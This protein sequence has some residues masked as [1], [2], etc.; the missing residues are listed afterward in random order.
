MKDFDKGLMN[1]YVE[2]MEESDM[3]V[4]KLRFKGY[5]SFT[6][7]YA[8]INEFANIT[9]FI[10]RNNSGKSS[11]IDIIENLISP[12]KLAK[13]QREQKDLKIE[14]AHFL[15]DDEVEKVFRKD[16]SGG[17]IQ[18][19]HYMFVQKYAGKEMYFNLET[20][21]KH[22]SGE[23]VSFEYKYSRVPNDKEFDEKY[24][25]YWDRFTNFENNDFSKYMF[26]RLEAERN[27]VAEGEST[28][29]DVDS[30]GTGA[31]NLIRKFLNYSE[32]DENIIE[33]NLINALNL[34]IFPDSKFTGIRVQQIQGEHGLLWE[35]FLQ[36]GRNRYAISQM[37]SGLKTVI[38]VLINLLLIP[39]TQE[40]KGK[41]IIYAF[42]ELENNLHPALQRRLFD[43]LY[44]Y[45][46][47]YDLMIYLTTHS[48]VAINAYCDRE[49]TQ[50]Y[51]V[52]KENGSSSLHK[53]DDY[54]AKSSLLNDLDVRASDLLQ[55]NGIVWVEGPSDRVYIKRWLEVFG[56]GELIEGRDYQIL[57]YGGRLL[58][59][60]SADDKQKE[61]LN[62]L[63][64]N[65][66]A[67]IVM[68]SDKRGRRSHIN[69][70]KKRVKEEFESFH[71]LCWITQGKEIENYI[72]YSA[73]EQAYDRKLDRQCGQYDL[74]PDYIKSIAP[75]FSGEKV[76]FA[77]KVCKYISAENSSEILDLKKQIDK[78][79][80]TIR[81]WNPKV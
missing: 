7:K 47:K 50:I 48:H 73:I 28:D 54:I 55:S 37:G 19:N 60:Y 75:H 79:I 13:R 39:Q 2:E 6:E 10:G 66:N 31:T 69:D 72:P 49:N 36:E 12:A 16:T 51:H 41:R 21:S 56:G 58:A 80:N 63:I 40:Y 74:F 78:L 17:M 8:A 57:Y 70:T 11:C 32:Y 53:I 61:L 29:E 9:V 34:I 5:K 71:A 1:Q 30:R 59:H 46:V 22:Y 33:K 44:E 25:A 24:H 45:S 27:I 76:I 81:R 67:A 18:G 20:K 38:L 64:T 15:T 43:F 77:N 3:K 23:N 42:E 26:R 35:I 68:D 65:R 14:I 52:T 62:V 4:S